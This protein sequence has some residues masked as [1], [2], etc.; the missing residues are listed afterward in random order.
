MILLDSLKKKCGYVPER[1]LLEQEIDT[2]LEQYASL[3][4]KYMTQVRFNVTCMYGFTSIMQS[5]D[6]N[7]IKEKVQELIQELPAADE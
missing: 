1:E 3:T 5:N 4:K 7:Y 2:L 6:I